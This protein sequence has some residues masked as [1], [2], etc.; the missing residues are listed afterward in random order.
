MEAER[1][2]E[3]SEK[4]EGEAALQMTLEHCE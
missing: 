2:M 3:E 4:G 1:G